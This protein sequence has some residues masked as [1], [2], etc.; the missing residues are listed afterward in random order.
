[1]LCDVNQVPPPPQFGRWSAQQ[2]ERKKGVGL[3]IALLLAVA[4]HGALFWYLKK[5]EFFKSATGE[6]TEE[7][8]YIVNTEDVEIPEVQ[9]DATQTLPDFTTE[10]EE[11]AELDEVLHQMQNQEI[12]MSPSVDAPEISI[13]MSVPAKAGELEGALDNVILNTD[14][15]TILEDIGTAITDNLLADQGQVVIKE[16]SMQG[17]LLNQSELIDDKTL[18]GINGFASD[19]V[20]QGYTSLDSLLS[21]SNS[22]LAGTKTAIPSDLL[23]GYDSA[24]LK[25]DARF[26]LMKLC[27]LYTSPSPRD[28]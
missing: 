10:R 15:D 14:S 19:G 17:E 18:Q 24:E 5:I 6:V 13:S 16:G 9:P 27:L 11:I 4:V 7:Q 25:V 21:M 28:A 20:M 22:K 8:T 3:F 12:D 26:G 1:M 2:P 23:F